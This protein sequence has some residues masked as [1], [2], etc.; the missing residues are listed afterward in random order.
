MTKKW[1]T[2]VFK[3]PPPS[4]KP[5]LVTPIE[6]IEEF[7]GQLPI[8]T[9]KDRGDYQKVR[10]NGS[11]WYVIDRVENIDS[12]NSY[13]LVS[14]VLCYYHLKDR[15]DANEKN[16]WYEQARKWVGLCI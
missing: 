9:V 2:Y 10:L 7:Q 14:K 13:M 8:G 6:F 16:T 15:D 11:W 1:R 5:T 3:A 12:K 4:T